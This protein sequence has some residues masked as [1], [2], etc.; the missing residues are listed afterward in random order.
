M[1]Q[2]KRKHH[3][4]HGESPKKQRLAAAPSFAGSWENLQPIL[5][6]WM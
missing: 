6:P 1:T 2:E 3:D 4:T 5:T